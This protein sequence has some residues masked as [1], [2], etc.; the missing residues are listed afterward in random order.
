MVNRLSRIFG[1]VLALIA[2]VGVA[3]MAQPAKPPAAT[4]GFVPV[5][6]LPPVDQL[7]AAPLVLG[8][9]AFIWLAVLV[10]VAV[11]WRRLGAVQKDL[12]ALKHAP[13]R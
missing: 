7:P 10:Y 1:L 13:P 5:G 4:D 6:D 11:L 2:S 3:V 12:D 8:A 9:Y